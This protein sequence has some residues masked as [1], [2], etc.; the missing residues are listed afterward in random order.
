MKLFSRSRKPSLNIGFPVKTPKDVL[1]GMKCLPYLMTDELCPECWME[2]EIPAYG[3]SLCPNCHK[4][5]IPCS[6]CYKCQSP[7]VYHVLDSYGNEGG[8]G[9]F[10]PWAGVNE[11]VLFYEVWD[12]GT[13]RKLAYQ[14][15]DFYPVEDGEYDWVMNWYPST[16]VVD[17]EEYR[18][19]GS[20]AFGYEGP[21]DLIDMDE[22]QAQ[23]KYFSL[24]EASEYLPIDKIGDDTEEGKYWMRYDI[25]P[26]RRLP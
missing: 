23:K 19:T 3:K 9:S 4:E 14:Q 22:E 7:C 6:M 24:L 20:D 26:Y 17:P 12:D 10:D 25:P 21:L 18:R 2:V 11:N 5:I 8:K 16:A 15:Y 13:G 1:K